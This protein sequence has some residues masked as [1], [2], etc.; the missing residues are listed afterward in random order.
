MKRRHLLAAGAAGLAMPGLAMPG[1]VRGQGLP[2]ASRL[3]KF[4]PQSDLTV[5]DPHWTT[6]YVTRKPRLHGVRHA[7]WH[8]RR[9]P[10]E[11]ADGGRPHRGS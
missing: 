4:I 8:Q 5:L 2:G 9:L 11:P 3:L 1:V 6:A 10:A 7:V